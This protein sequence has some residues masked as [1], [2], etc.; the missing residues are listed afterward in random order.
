MGLLTDGGGVKKTSP[1]TYPI[2]TKRGKVIPYLKEIQKNINHVTHPLTSVDI[3][4]FL[5]EIR[6]CCYIKKYRYRFYFD[7]YLIFF[8]NFLESLKIVLINMVTIFMMSAKMAAL[9]LLKIKLFWNKGYDAINSVHDVTNKILSC[10]SN[11]IVNVVMWPKFGNCRIS[12]R[13]VIINSI[14]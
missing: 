10:D 2:M 8:L 4:I 14:L 7:P 5:L 13:E 6:K 12:M 9:A 3:S 11:Y 1:H